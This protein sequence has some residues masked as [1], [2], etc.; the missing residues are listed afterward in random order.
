MDID[1]ARALVRD[2]EIRLNDIASELRDIID[3]EVMGDR[4]DA[5]LG[6]A[7]RTL[8]ALAL[9]IGGMEPGSEA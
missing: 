7:E 1:E 3:A 2:I 5:E 4:Y 8:E 6:N 9:D